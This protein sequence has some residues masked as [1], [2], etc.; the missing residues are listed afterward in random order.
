MKGVLPSFLETSRTKEREEEKKRRRKENQVETWHCPEEEP[1]GMCVQRQFLR[2][3]GGTDPE[4]FLGAIK[5]LWWP[6]LAG[7]Q[8][9]KL[10]S[11]F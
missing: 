8:G 6:A 3:E 1:S 5:F 7:G 11:G 4:G 9:T 10:S 2:T